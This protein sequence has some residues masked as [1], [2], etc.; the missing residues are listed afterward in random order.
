[1]WE[2]EEWEVETREG[3]VLRLQRTASGWTVEGVLD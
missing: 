1:M 2:R 3:T